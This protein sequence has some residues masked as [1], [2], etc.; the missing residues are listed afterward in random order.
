MQTRTHNRRPFLWTAAAATLGLA[1]TIAFP[2][3]AG[4]QAKNKK[5]PA[6]AQQPAAKLT[7]QEFPDGTGTIGLPTG[8]RIIDSY[9]GTVYCLGPKG[10]LVKQGS[11]LVI[12][13]PDHPA[14]N[15][16][17]P[18]SAPLA[19]DGDLV[20]ALQGVLQKANNKLISLRSRPAP[21]P[22]P[23]IP[24]AYFLYEL[25]DANGKRMVAMGYFSALMESD[26]TL[27][28]WQ[29]YVSVV[30]APKEIFMQELPTLL[31]IQDTYRPNGLAPREGSNGAM[32]D[33]G[34]ARDLKQRRANLAEQQAMFDRMNETFK[35]VIKQ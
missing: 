14:N 6:A 15:M 1:L 35:A 31:A 26:Q 30:M 10:Q 29:L 5:A 9:R 8:W 7:T 27:P 28:Y 13:R 32:I 12:A 33:A 16:G 19:R 3:V 4:A 17:I 23:G 11:A 20:G 18:S 21:S 24:A 22:R 34:I 25:E 2:T